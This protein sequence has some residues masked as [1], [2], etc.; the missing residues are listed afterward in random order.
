MGIKAVA[1]DFGNVISAPQDPETMGLLA[2]I[3]DVSE[4]DA[5]D[6]AF[7]GRED[8]DRGDLSGPDH[9]RRGFARLGRSNVDEGTINAFMRADL[10]SWAVINEDSVRL[11]E[12]V[13]SAGL[14]T[15]IL[16]NMPHEFI[17]TARRRFP[18]IG[19]VDVGVFSAEHSV[20]KPDPG[21]YTILLEKLG[22]RAADVLFFD[23]VSANVEAALA[24]GMAAFLWTDAPNARITLRERGIL[25]K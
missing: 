10:E 12:D 3:G 16:S 13:S 14:K 7:N 5:R 19:K 9:Y 17:S 2:A 20:V 25:A 1:F 22:L 4:E 11:I 6:I 23:D 24:I 18:V 21:I 15:A 8:W